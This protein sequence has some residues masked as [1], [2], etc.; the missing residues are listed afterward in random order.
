[1]E[2]ADSP[3]RCHLLLGLG[4]HFW[5]PQLALHGARPLG[6]RGARRGTPPQHVLR[7]QVSLH[8]ETLA[9]G[10]PNSL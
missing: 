5:A 1:M 7:R 4:G 2:L 3:C 6:Q 9:S 8:T 10:L